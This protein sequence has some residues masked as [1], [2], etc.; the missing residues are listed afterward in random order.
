MTFVGMTLVGIPLFVRFSRG[1]YWIWRYENR[2]LS[3]P[4][5][6]PGALVTALRSFVDWVT[7][8]THNQPPTQWRGPGPTPRT[9]NLREQASATFGPPWVYAVIAAG[10][11]Q[12]RFDRQVAMASSPTAYDGGIVLALAHSEANVVG[13]PA[14]HVA[15]QVVVKPPTLPRTG[16]TPWLPLA[17]ASFLGLALVT[18]RLLVARD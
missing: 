2:D 18:R 12:V 5:Q 10:E 1:W 4:A 7:R 6:E 3:T 11:A 8:A 16:G 9:S 15:P 14:T 17:G 13:V